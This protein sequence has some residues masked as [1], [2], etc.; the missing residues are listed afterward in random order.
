MWKG[1]VTHPETALVS[2][3]KR[4]GCQEH[5]SLTGLAGRLPI[6]T[7]AGDEAPPE[8]AEG[9]FWC[10]LLRTSSGDRARSG[11]GC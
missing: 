8:L 7:A 6:S 4:S 11:G 10:A 3:P 1:V 5:S 9:W 2:S